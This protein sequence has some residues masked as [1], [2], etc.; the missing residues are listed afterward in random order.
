[1]AD[2]ALACLNLKFRK[3]FDYHMFR[4]ICELGTRVHKFE[5]LMKEENLEIDAAMV[6]E[7]SPLCVIQCQNLI[8]M[9]NC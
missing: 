1:M 4:D 3:K 2:L 5:S 9:N 8:L 7:K 6:I